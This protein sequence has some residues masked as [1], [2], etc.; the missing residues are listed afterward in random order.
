M[1]GVGMT[2][3]DACPGTLLVQV[4]TGVQSGA[5]A[6]IGG[7]L[8]GI[9]YTAVNDQLRRC[10]PKTTGSPEAGTSLHGMP[11]TPRDM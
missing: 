4:G 10:P 6:L 2:L 5:S 9:L 3:T 1:V 8:G 7:I 11:K